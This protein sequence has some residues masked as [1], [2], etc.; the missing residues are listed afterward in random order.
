MTGAE[1]KVFTAGKKNGKAQLTIYLHTFEVFMS[2]IRGWEL[3]C[4]N[5]S[6]QELFFS[7]TDFVIW[8]GDF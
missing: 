6:C 7:K 8:N 4:R 1:K 5:V 3:F 2:F